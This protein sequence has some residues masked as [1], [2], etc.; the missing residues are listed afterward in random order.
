MFLTVMV[1]SLV[2]GLVSGGK[3]SRLADVDLDRVVWIAGSFLVKIAS[4]KLLSGRFEPYPQV[5]L[6]LSFG[7]YLMLFYGLYP[8]LRLRGFGV[9]AF[10]VF[11][12]FLV[13]MANGGRMPVDL[14]PLGPDVLGSQISVLSSSFTHCMLGDNTRLTFLADIFSWKFLS[15]APTTFSLGDI[16]MAAGIFLF[17]MST[18]HA[19]FS[20]RQKN[21]RIKGR[22]I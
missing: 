9:L 4:I 14:S 16:F 19:S 10:G 5:C 1:V 2:V 22:D 15:R 7:T 21:G 20:Q 8:N 11:L 17:I 18:M 3:I 6:A 12:N 13:I